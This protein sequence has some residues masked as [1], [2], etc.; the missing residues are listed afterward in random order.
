MTL[1][2]V[3][4]ERAGKVAE[5]SWS[6]NEKLNLRPSRMKENEFSVPKGGDGTYTFTLTVK[7]EAGQTF[8][9]ETAVTVPSPGYEG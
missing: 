5:Y 3:V 4:A 9:T 7:N 1:V 8:S 2:A 6:G